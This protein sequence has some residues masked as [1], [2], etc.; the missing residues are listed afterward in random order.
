M[1]RQVFIFLSLLALLAVPPAV[2][3]QSEFTSGG[4]AG[5]VKD[6]TGADWNAICNNLEA[7]A[8]YLPTIESHQPCQSHAR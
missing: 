4:I 2:L 1:S 7:L 8:R 3:A 6:G 5:T